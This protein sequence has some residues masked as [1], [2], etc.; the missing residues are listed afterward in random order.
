M[1]KPLA[2][3]RKEIAEA[4]ALILKALAKRM[5][6]VA[7]VG[8]YK[9]KHGLP[10]KDFGVEKQIY[11]KLRV[12]AQK[13]QL[14]E[15]FCEEVF[16]TIIEFSVKSQEETLRKKAYGPSA[17]SQ[18]I[19]VIGG[20]GLMGRWLAQ[21]FDSEGHQVAVYDP[22]APPSSFKQVETLLELKDYDFLFLA[23]PLSATK[24]VIEELT[25]LSVSGVLVDICSLKSPI[26]GALDQAVQRGLRVSSIHPMF[27]PT[28][29]TLA[30][31]NI[32][33]CDEPDHVPVSLVKA[34]FSNTSANLIDI[35]FEK[36]DL[37]MSLVLGSA[38]L[39]NILYAGV[40]AKGEFSRSQLLQVAGT[41]FFH[42]YQV[43]GGVIA[44]NQDLYYE[45]Q[46][47]NHRSE[48]LLQVMEKVLGDFRAAILQKD[49][50][51]FKQLME[52]GRKFFS[53]LD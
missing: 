41:T 23:T 27:G 40:L 39:I 3:L 2:E 53:S 1:D 29:K 10:V 15:E 21:Y 6:C 30:G 9:K 12:S 17:H 37:L 5:E 34:L 44:E 51:S 25:E 22:L 32:L 52:E 50:G 14:D 28:V 43:T 7:K 13:F 47:E 45:I 49:R 38:H 33:F 4:D 19:A 42:Q 35:D 31:R 24:G 16:R 20:G 11:D 26:T 8:D 36:H 46:V 18:K 48:D